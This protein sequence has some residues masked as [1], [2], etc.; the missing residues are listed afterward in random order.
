MNLEWFGYSPKINSN[1]T[2]DL[3]NYCL[4]KSFKLRLNEEIYKVNRLMDF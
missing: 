4:R 2:A 3:L 1:I